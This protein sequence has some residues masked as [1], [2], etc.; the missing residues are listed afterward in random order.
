MTDYESDL[1]QVAI[2]ACDLPSWLARLLGDKEGHLRKNQ[3]VK[4][5][6]ILINLIN[7]KTL[8]FDFD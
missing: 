3:C 7:Y 4:E 1:Q 6:I 5:L 8:I 2:L